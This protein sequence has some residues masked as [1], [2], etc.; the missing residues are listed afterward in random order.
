MW[1]ITKFALITLL[2]LQS[3]T[4]PNQKKKQVCKSA[5]THCGSLMC[6]VFRWGW[7]RWQKFPHQKC[8]WE[9]KYSSNA[10]DATEITRQK[11]QT[12]VLVL[13]MWMLGLHHVVKAVLCA[14]AGLS[15]LGCSNQIIRGNL[16]VNLVSFIRC[17][18]IAAQ[19]QCHFLHFC[20]FAGFWIQARGDWKNTT[21]NAAVDKENKYVFLKI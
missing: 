21:L 18:M 4:L 1:R 7:R 2:C 3:P 14:Q 20:C 16:A 15:A 11:L 8:R 9:S 13:V 10:G 5:H 17:S 19:L 12:L 6:G